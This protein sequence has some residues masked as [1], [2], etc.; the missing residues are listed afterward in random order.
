MGGGVWVGTVGAPHVRGLARCAHLPV[1]RCGPCCVRG[2]LGKTQTC[3]TPLSDME[4]EGEGEGSLENDAVEVS[5]AE[6]EAEADPDRD[7]DA[8]GEDD[9]DT[10]VLVP[11]GVLVPAADGVRLS[12][13]VAAGVEVSLGV[14]ETEAVSDTVTL[15]VGEPVS[16]I[17]TVAVT[18]TVVDM[19]DVAVADGGGVN[20]VLAVGVRPVE[21]DVAAGDHTHPCNQTRHSL[22]G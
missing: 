14:G 1:A 9:V 2:G 21:A 6:A 22:T 4:G 19:D 10:G 17:L 5:E 18:E 13:D 16:L 15:M 8:L 11:V 7:G 20:D 12:E 3:H